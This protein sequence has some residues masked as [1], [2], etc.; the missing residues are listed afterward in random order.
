MKKIFVI[1]GYHPEKER[2]YN[3]EHI[4]PV[5]QERDHLGVHY[6][7]LPNNGWIKDMGDN[8]F[9]TDWN[10]KERWGRVEE[11]ELDDKTGE[12]ISR[13]VLGFM[14]LRVDRSRGVL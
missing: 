14:I 3:G 8:K 4:Y 13:K 11:A 5:I 6:W 1:S 9:L 10:D 7:K 2:E 12:E